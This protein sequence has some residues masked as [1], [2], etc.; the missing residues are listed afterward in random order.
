MNCSG[1]RP[2]APQSEDGDKLP[3]L[4]Y[5]H[6]RFLAKL[7]FFCA[8]YIGQCC[9]K[10]LQA[11]SLIGCIQ[12]DK[13]FSCVILNLLFISYGMF[14]NIYFVW[15]VRYSGSIKQKCMFKNKFPKILDE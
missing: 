8:E 4:R 1:I 10:F 15:Y 6:V 7:F 12:R 14:V 11:G 3:E 13:N 2:Q 9:D 5:D